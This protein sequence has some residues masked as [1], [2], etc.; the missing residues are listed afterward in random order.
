M[1]VQAALDELMKERTTFVIA[2]RR[3]T[4]RN[5]TRILVFNHGRIV[6]TGSFDELIQR[7]GVFAALAKAQFLVTGSPEAAP[8]PV[9]A[10]AREPEPAEPPAIVVP[11]PNEITEGAAEEPAT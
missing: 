8:A 9:A 2:H 10:S 5:A 4:V 11:P 6:E 3:S 7:G 1:K